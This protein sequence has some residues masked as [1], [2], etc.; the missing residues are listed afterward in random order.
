M[1]NK[2]ESTSIDPSDVLVTAD[3]TSLYTN[4]KLGEAYCVLY[5]FLY[6]YKDF[7]NTEARA[8]MLVNFIKV[9]MENNYFTYRG[10]IFKQICG[11]AMGCNVAPV[12][13]NLFVAAYE[14][15]NIFNKEVEKPKIYL[16]YIDDVF[17]IWANPDTL[18]DFK[19]LINDMSPSLKFT[20]EQ[21]DS[22]S[23][24]DVKITKSVSS[25]LILEC[26][27]KPNNPLLYTH[28]SSYNKHSYR[29]NWIQGECIRLVRLSSTR[30]LYKKALIS[31]NVALIRRGYPLSIINKQVAL[32]DYDNR[33]V[34]L[35]G[36]T[37]TDSVESQPIVPKIRIFTKN[38]P[39]R[40]IMVRYFRQYV[41]LLRISHEENAPHVQ[42]VVKK[43][44]SL[45]DIINRSVKQVL[46]TPS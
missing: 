36:V 7:Y 24:L 20:F 39:G 16:R 32:V 46:G 38:I 15:W 45:M 42:I 17:F 4:I 19:E 37:E 5:A 41:E 8:A 22:V 35:R 29:F 21:G 43:G 12:F 3:V 27:R 23:F 11:T 18:S 2:L 33:E 9:V 1:I 40:H 13:A 25:S 30:E 31:F 10:N 34:Y 14:W 44:T 6:R 28:P 26:Y